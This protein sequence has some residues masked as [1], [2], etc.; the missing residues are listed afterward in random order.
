MGLR[1]LRG[2][3]HDE[4]R[5]ERPGWNLLADGVPG[6]ETAAEVGRRVDRVIERARAGGGDTLLRRPR[7]RAAGAGRPLGRAC[8]PAGGRLLALDA[9]VGAACLGWER[10]IPV[11]YRWNEQAPAG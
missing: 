5:R 9:G 10:E 2:P 8:R 6:G 4:I 1:R 7:A 3:H 11:I